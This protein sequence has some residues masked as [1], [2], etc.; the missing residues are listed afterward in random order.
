MRIKKVDLHYSHE[1]G[2]RVATIEFEGGQSVQTPD[3]ALNSSELAYKTRGLCWQPWDHTVFE[4]VRNLDERKLHDLAGRNGPMAA[5]IKHA[6]S[7]FKKTA[8][9]VRLFFPRLAFV[10]LTDPEIR[11]LIDLQRLGGADMIC[12][13]DSRPGDLLNRFEKML[14]GS[15]EYMEMAFGSRLEPFPLID[16]REPADR[17]SAKVLTCLDMG[18]KLIAFRYASPTQ[19]YANY[20]FLADH[21]R[22]EVWLHLSGVERF[23]RQNYTTSQ[24]HIP[25]FAGVDTVSLDI[26]TG[27]RYKVTDYYKVKRFDPRSI[28]HLDRA[29]HLQRYDQDLACS[30]QLCS[31]KQLDEFYDKNVIGPKSKKPMVHRLRRVAAVHEAFS[32]RDEFALGRQRILNGEAAAYVSSKEFLGPALTVQQLTPAGGPR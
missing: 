27:G 22:N 11:T 24:L 30:C 6:A 21:N 19:T 4:L 25:Q 8:G 17:F 1:Y 10:D 12:L 20:R 32:S 7:A 13:P 9:K 5:E 23:W 28:G 18:F 15:R 2:P 14:K 31:G 26:P 29:M 16:M 3:R